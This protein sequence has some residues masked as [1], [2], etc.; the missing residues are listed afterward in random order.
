MTCPF[1]LR[2]SWWLSGILLVTRS[3]F[4]TPK[5]DGPAR[6]VARSFMPATASL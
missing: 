5:A 4:L 2:L 1:C 6:F 3:L